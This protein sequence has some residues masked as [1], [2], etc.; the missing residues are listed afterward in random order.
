MSSVLN[1]KMD[2]KIKEEIQKLAKQ[3]N[4]TMANYIET[5][6]KRHVEEKKHA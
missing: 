3:D 6:L 4:R 1:M 5:I 2:P